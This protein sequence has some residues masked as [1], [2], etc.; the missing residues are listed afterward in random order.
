MLALCLDG[1]VT[2]DISFLR[3]RSQY[4]ASFVIPSASVLF[5]LRHIS[6]VPPFFCP[7]LYF[8]EADLT[9]GHFSRSWILIVNLSVC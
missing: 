7:S 5:V 3:S 2:A 1:S 8:L 9:C 4:G 6:P